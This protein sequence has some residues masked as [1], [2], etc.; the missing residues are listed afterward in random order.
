MGFLA[1]RDLSASKVRMVAP[2]MTAPEDSWSCRLS[3]AVIIVTTAVAD[4][5]DTRRRSV[6]EV[7]SPT[8]QM[9]SHPTRLPCCD[10]PRSAKMCSIRSFI[11]DLVRPGSLAMITTFP[12]ATGVDGGI[13][14]QKNQ[15]RANVLWLASCHIRRTKAIWKRAQRN[16]STGVAVL[17]SAHHTISRQGPHLDDGAEGSFIPA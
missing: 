13:R 9:K 5:A 14:L 4:M 7:G 11:T 10:T 16:V 6:T 15:R 2:L 8:R 1:S 12:A 17:P 3:S